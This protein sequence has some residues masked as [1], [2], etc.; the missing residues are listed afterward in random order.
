MTTRDPS[1]IQQLRAARP[2][3]PPGELCMR[4]ADELERLTALAQRIA[5]LEANPDASAGP[6]GP[7]PN[8]GSGGKRSALEVKVTT[9]DIEP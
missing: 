2:G 6:A 1:L 8:Q 5:E 4:A 3:Y 9:Q 7:P